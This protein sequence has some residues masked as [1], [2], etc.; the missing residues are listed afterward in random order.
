MM[1]NYQIYNC[2]YLNNSLDKVWFKN[3]D[4]SS[5]Q[6]TDLQNTDLVGEISAEFV[7]EG[8]ES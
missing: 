8:L 6:N 3:W 7:S 5:T 2:F 1:L 4:H